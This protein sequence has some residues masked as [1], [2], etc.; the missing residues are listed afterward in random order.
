M[1]KA[2]LFRIVLSGVIAV[3]LVAE[4]ADAKCTVLECGSNSPVI[5]TY[6]FHELHPG[7]AWNDADLRVVGFTA[8]DGTPYQPW[9][10]GAELVALDANWNVVLSGTQLQDA[11]IV[12]ESRD[13]VEQYRIHIEHV[14]DSID[15]W[16]DP[17]AESGVL[18][19]QLT[20][21]GPGIEGRQPVC[22]KPPDKKTPG[23]EG[24]GYINPLEA[25]LYTG[26][27]YSALDKTVTAIGFGATRGWFNI[28]CAGSAIYKLHMTRFTT[29]GANALHVTTAGERQA[30]LKMWVSDVCGDGDSLTEQGTPLHWDNPFGWGYVTGDEYATEALWSADGALC[31]D[32]HRLGTLYQDVLDTCPL[33]RCKEEFP[34][35]DVSWPAEATVISKVPYKPAI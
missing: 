3:A 22:P 10:F 20:Y 27:R 9:V 8:A 5:K 16:V 26:D 12:L 21:T 32:T 25:I 35:Y 1:R 34:D 11:T 19:Y 15:F 24:E 13:P 23:L 29:A 14:T 33:R 30:M 7:G 18:T 31:L 2:G 17:D 28:A 6:R 4:R